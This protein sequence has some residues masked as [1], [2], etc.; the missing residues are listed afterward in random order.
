MV[1]ITKT[2]FFQGRRPISE[3]E[4]H[5][6]EIF[7]EFISPKQ[8]SINPCEEG[9]TSKTNHANLQNRCLRRRSLWAGS[10]RGSSKGKKKRIIKIPP[11]FFTNRFDKMNTGPSSRR[12]AKTRYQIRFSGTFT[13]RREYD[14]PL[15]LNLGWEVVEV[16]RDGSA[17]STQPALHLQMK[18]SMQ[19]R[20]QMP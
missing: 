1:F 4:P 7:I 10:H 9:K 8:R 11:I 14:A 15:F 16:D 18:L 5:H 2:L 20:A 3:K 6:H 19:Q 17:L 13:R 12:E